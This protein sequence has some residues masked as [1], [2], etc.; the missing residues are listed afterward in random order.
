MFNV[1]TIA[2]RASVLHKI[3][4]CRLSQDENFNTSDQ[5]TATLAPGIVRWGFMRCVEN[6]WYFMIDERPYYFV[7]LEHIQELHEI[8]YEDIVQERVARP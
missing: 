7:K 2:A 5:Y 6:K 1:P 3:R 8:S 4:V